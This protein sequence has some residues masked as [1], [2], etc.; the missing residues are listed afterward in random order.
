MQKESSVS[1]ADRNEVRESLKFGSVHLL[2]IHIYLCVGETF[3]FAGVVSMAMGNQNFRHLLRLVAKSLESIHI[4]ADVLAGEDGRILI[5]HFF[6][7]P[8]RN[9]GIYENHLAAPKSPPS[10]VSSTG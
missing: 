5:G 9:A 6:G 8:S 7:S 4:A 2:L 1:I 10:P 3:Q